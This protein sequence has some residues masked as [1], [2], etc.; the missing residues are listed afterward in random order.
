MFVFVILLAGAKQQSDVHLTVMIVETGIQFRCATN[1][2]SNG[3]FPAKITLTNN[4]DPHNVH[5]IMTFHQ[6]ACVESLDM[7]F[8]RIACRKNINT[9]QFVVT[10][11]LDNVQETDL[12]SWTCT[13]YFF[14]SSTCLQ[15]IVASTTGVA[16]EKAA[17]KTFTNAPDSIG[18]IS[19][20]S[21]DIGE[22]KVSLGC[23][24]KGG[25]NFT[26]TG[27]IVVP[28][29]ELS[30][31]INDRLSFSGDV[32]G[33]STSIE[34]TK[35]QPCLQGENMQCFFDGRGGSK[36]P[37]VHTY[38]HLY[39]TEDSVHFLPL[40]SL[41]GFLYPNQSAN[42]VLN[43]D[44]IVEPPDQFRCYNVVR[45]DGEYCP[46]TKIMNE[47]IE[48]LVA[49]IR[50]YARLTIK[51]VTPARLHCEKGKLIVLTC[52]KTRAVRTDAV[53]GI[54][55][56][57]YYY[58]FTMKRPIR[59]HVRL[60]VLPSFPY[61]KQ[62]TYFKRL[63]LVSPIMG[64]PCVQV[65]NTCASLGTEIVGTVIVSRPI[66]EYVTC[67]VFGRR[68]EPTRVTNPCRLHT[69]Q[70]D[71]H[72]HVDCA[73]CPLLFHRRKWAVEHGASPTEQYLGRAIIPKATLIAT[74]ESVTCRGISVR[75]KTLVTADTCTVAV[76]LG[77]DE[78]LSPICIVPYMSCPILLEVLNDTSGHILA[79][80]H[81]FSCFHILGGEIY[82]PVVADNN[83]VYRCRVKTT[84]GMLLM[85]PAK[86]IKQI[87]ACSVPPP[88]VIH[89][90]VASTGD[91]HVLCQ[92]CGG[93]TSI[94]SME[95]QRLDGV[96]A[97]DKI[98][99]NLAIYT[100]HDKTIVNTTIS[101]F[102]MA[103]GYTTPNRNVLA[104]TISA[105]FFHQLISNSGVIVNITCSVG[106]I[107]R[108]VNVD[109]AVAYDKDTACPHV[110]K[111]GVPGEES[112]KTTIS[113]THH[114][115]SIKAIFLAMIGVGAVMSVTV[116]VAACLAPKF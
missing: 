48:A 67:S 76:E 56:T 108:S 40:D 1:I 82:L 8:H 37:P 75:T 80:C 5:E 9:G 4:R 22:E 113:Y 105:T 102:V 18:D 10:A 94:L 107:K 68:S 96:P 29:K 101:Q 57:P 7:K 111:W 19:V 33:R 70:V 104:A 27:G 91:L 86:T 25:G 44:V 77:V 87:S 23:R 31:H 52:D 51:T 42:V 24:V 11:S 3:T 2:N 26:V 115:D 38:T 63:T 69:H 116:L 21:R 12:G 74:Y 55:T 81:T 45:G 34:A 71:H 20:V 47:L 36:C 16:Y 46:S 100:P 90:H 109:L 98:I 110:T 54:C 53:K 83:T 58:C 60:I 61:T 99:H 73:S 93:E 65:P 97:G 41:Q 13:G 95:V 32:Y 15:Y 43:P 30:F 112:S 92:Y 49:G 72:I 89:Q 106:P 79:S 64:C 62:S 39:D 114:K 17:V 6:S 28:M 59:R 35:Q 103:N 14:N 66:N 84:D 85:S 50:N 78:T 88:V